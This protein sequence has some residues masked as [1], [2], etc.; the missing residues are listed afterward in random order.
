M[1][2]LQLSSSTTSLDKSWYSQK[3]HCGTTLSHCNES[4]NYIPVFTGHRPEPEHITRQPPVRKVIR[5]ENRCIQALSLPTILSYNMRSLWGKIRSLATDIH[6]R[7]GEIIFLSEVW[8]KRENKSHKHKI[9]ELLE[10]SNISYISTPRQGSKR[11]GGAAIAISSNKFSVKKLNI[12]IPTPLEIVWAMLRPIEHTGDIRKIILCSLYSPPNSRKNALLVDHISLTYNML[13]IQHPDAGIIISG[14][15]NNLD[16]K[17]IVAL[18]PNF[19]QIVTQNTRHEKILTIIITDLHPYYHIPTIIPPVPVDVPGQGVPSDHD[20]V[21]AL[22]ITTAN[23]KRTPEIRKITVRP[24]PESLMCKFGTKMVNEDWLFLLPH[25]SPTEMVD[26]FTNYTQNMV[27]TSFPE[28]IVKIS[29]WDKP[30]MTQELKQLRRKRQ[31]IYRLKGKCQKYV[32]LKAEFDQKIKKEAEKFR[33]KILAEVKSGKLGSSYSALRKLDAN[34]NEKKKCGFTL[35]SHAEENLTPLQSA[36]KLADYFSLISQEFEPINFEKFPPNIREKLVAG[37]SDKTK[38][39]LNE[40][41]VYKRILRSKKPNTLLPG[42]LPVKLLKEFSPELAT[43][44]STIFNR[45]TETAEYPRQWVIEHQIAIPKVQS[46]SSEDETRNI[47]ST[48]FFSKVYESFIGD[49]IFPFIAPFLDPGQCGGLKGSSITHYLVKLLHFVHSYLDLTQPHAVLLALIDLEKAFNR[50]SHQHVIEDL[51][52][53]KVPGWLLLILVSYLTDRSMHMRYKGATSSRRYLPGSSPQG[54]FLGILLFIIIF[55]GAL[56]R[57]RIPRLSSLNLKYIDD[58]SMLYALNLKKSLI[59]DPINRPRPLT[60]DERTQQVLE[61][62]N[63]EFQ[64]SLDDLFSFVSSKNMK[65]KEK[66]TELMK[67]NFS[68]SND[69]PPEFKIAGFAENIEVKKETK[70]LGVVLTTDLKWERNTEFI[71][72]KAYKRIWILRR[73]K[74][75]DIEPLYLLEVYLKEIRSILELA[76]P[77]W[78]SGLTLKQSA[79]IER[80]QRVAVSIILSDFQTRKSHMPYDMAL[81]TLGIEPLYHGREILC[82]NF[83]VKTVKSRHF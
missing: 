4:E 24:M 48:S 7:S 22:P 45:I 23:G 83:A 60:H 38:P 12:F 10:M 11:G 74:Q 50:V 15:K 47:A 73:L 33:Q 49:W 1:D 31:R 26:C 61:L 58:L 56:L 79:D 37:K 72:S 69:F 70:L 30:Y 27:E 3:S 9:E 17:K 16:D 76:V 21:L 59:K 65:I 71:C 34:F 5:R 54:A 67:F 14:D 19:R 46:P 57:P 78:H 44:V 80:V 39:V 82:K 77:A 28:K 43:P 29:N 2:L 66:K 68:T 81:V 62:G 52:D 42:D 64:N 63:N 75:L 18:N 36:E 55:N 8:E 40:W 20:G 32:Q 13:K 53:M 41:Q 51:A 35:P 25:M 6:E